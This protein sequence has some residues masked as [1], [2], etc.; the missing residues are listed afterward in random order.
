MSLK[1]TKKP[2]YSQTKWTNFQLSILIT[3]FLENKFP[4]ITEIFRQVR[5]CYKNTCQRFNK[6]FEYIFII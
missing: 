4:D 6:L 1:Q 2:K 3:L 5:I